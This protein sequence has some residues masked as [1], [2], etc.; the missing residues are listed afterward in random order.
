M[1]LEVGGG[2][3]G[4]EYLTPAGSCCLSY[5]IIV[6]R[7]SLGNPENDLPLIAV[8]NGSACTS[9]SIE[10]SWR[11]RSILTPSIRCNLKAVKCVYELYSH[12][13]PADIDP[14]IGL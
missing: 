9:A 10:P 8:S 11:N 12:A 6:C 5:F 1:H 3:I 7:D 14:P 13:I 4:V 2:V